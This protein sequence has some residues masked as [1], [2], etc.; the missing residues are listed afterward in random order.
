MTIEVKTYDDFVKYWPFLEQGSK[1]MSK[2]SQ[3]TMDSF[4]KSMLGVAL[5][6]R[7]GKLVILASK[8]EKLLGYVAV[9]EVTIDA[10]QPIAEIYSLFSN[11]KD[12]DAEIKLV[13]EANKWSREQGYSR[14]QMNC[15]R[16]NGSTIR[17]FKQL[18]LRQQ[19]IVFE[20]SV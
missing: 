18:G 17:F 19:R 20:G 14:L 13:Q 9:R 2:D 8:N 4:L 16:I 1:H 7:N 15:Y 12:K 6:P 5:P 3:H 11:G 10:D